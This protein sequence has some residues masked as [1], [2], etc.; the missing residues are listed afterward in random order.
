MD[1]VKPGL[2]FWFYLGI[3]SS[4]ASVTSF[5]KTDFIEKTTGLFSFFPILIVLIICFTSNLKL[6][7]FY[8]SSPR[9]QETIRFFRGYERAG[10]TIGFTI[11][12]FGNVGLFYFSEKSVAFMLT[13]LFLSFYCLCILFC[14]QPYTDF[15]A[16]DFFVSASLNQTLSLFKLRSSYFWLGI[17]AFIVIEGIRFFLE[18][19]HF[20]EEATSNQTPLQTGLLHSMT[21]PPPPGAQSDNHPSS[22]GS[23]HQMSANPLS[24]GDA[25]GHRNIPPG[26]GPPRE[27]LPEFKSRSDKAKQLMEQEISH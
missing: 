2:G 23:S 22:S 1:P 11:L 19:K 21:D 13:C 9:N 17:S 8:W 20:P 14:I 3:I 24:E 16:L 10:K 18:P 27:N 25:I 5:L 4:L 7:Q 6:S 15:G 26:R 12:L